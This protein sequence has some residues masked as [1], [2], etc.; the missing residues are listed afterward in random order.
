MD[1]RLEE[2]S[3]RYASGDVPWDAPEPPPEVIAL[4]RAQEPGRALDLGTGYGRAALYLARLG[5]AVDAVDFVP[6]AIREARRRAEAEGLETVC[7]HL[8]AVTELDHLKPSYD[9]ALDVGCVHGLPAMDLPLYCEQLRRLLAPGGVYLLFARLRDADGEEPEHGL[10]ED[11]LK[12]ELTET[13]V[14]ER[15]ERGAT[16]M[17]DSPPWPSAWFW[18]RRKG[19][20]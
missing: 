4:A 11:R 18:F 9:L 3:A 12:Q 10:D 6:Q 19:D 2:L 8:G 5:W 1:D 15:V 20:G 7:F 13:F 14:L 16:L 17:A